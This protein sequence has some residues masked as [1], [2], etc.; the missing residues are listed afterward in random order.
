MTAP[1]TVPTQVAHPW[2]ATARTLVQ[3]ALGLL[4]LSPLIAQVLG[5]EALPWVAAVLAAAAGFTRLMAVPVI[6]DWV[7]DYLPWLAPAP[8]K[9]QA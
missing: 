5:I 3:G 1:S 7:H 6:A 2:R 4:L 9:P 8:P